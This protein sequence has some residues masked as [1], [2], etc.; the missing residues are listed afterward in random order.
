M[1]VNMS[2]PPGGDFWYVAS[3]DLL[4]LARPAL[5]PVANVI[6]WP[7]PWIREWLLITSLLSELS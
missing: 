6:M 3:V 7:S 4:E 1:D 5:T 2:V